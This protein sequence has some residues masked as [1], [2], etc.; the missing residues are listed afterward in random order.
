MAD[1]TPTQTPAT[2]VAQLKQKAND[3]CAKYS[4]K[5]NYNPHIHVAQKIT[6]LITELTAKDATVTPQILAKVAAL[7]DELPVIN[8]DYKPEVTGIGKPVATAAAVGAQNA[9]Q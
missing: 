5:V 7:P 2:L 3:W 9:K 6:P 4:G 1:P 8:P